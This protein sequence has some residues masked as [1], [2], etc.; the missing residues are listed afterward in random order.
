MPIRILKPTSSG[1]RN[2]SVDAFED[3]T[4]HEPEKSLTVMLPTHAGR[5]IQGKVTVR[6]RVGGAKRYYRLIDF[7]QDRYD[8]PAVVEAI[9]YDPYRSARIA[10]IKYADGE[11][12]YIVAPN[13]LKV[14]AAVISSRKPVE[15]KPGNRMPLKYIP[16][17]Q[18][19]FSI[20]LEPATRGILVRSAGESAVL[21]ALENGYA[22]VQLPSGEVRKVSQDASA[23]LG[24]VS[25]P[26]R[27]LI[28]WGKAGRMRH[29]GRRPTV[30]GKAMN[31]VDHPH[32]GGEGHNPIGLTRPKTP[33]GKPA[34]GV[35]TRKR[36]KWSD[37]LIIKR[38]R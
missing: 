5:N 32:G 19:I 7:K 16:V 31:P 9:E 11:R 2:I 1:R 8:L 13:G 15:P 25:N 38:R 14:G 29:K 18:P 24:Q 27:R 30:R 33:W 35:K 20:E 23:T 3:I 21:L 28:R 12:R 10:L 17:G 4:K 34:L 37:S 6:H 26:D 22:Q 36:E